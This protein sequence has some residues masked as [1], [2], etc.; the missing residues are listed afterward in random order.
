M[1]ADTPATVPALPAGV[2]LQDARLIDLLQRALPLTERPFADVGAELGLDEQQVIER[3]RRLLA[4]GVLTRFGP[5]FHIERAGGQFILA[6]LQAP[7]DRYDE[8]TA[9]VNALPEVAHNYRREHTLNM[10]F[11]VAAETSEGAWAAC[12]RIEAITGLPVHAFPKEREFFVGLYLPLLADSPRTS[13]DT[14]HATDA[15]VVASAPLSLTDF[16]RRL[17][18]V[19]QT[20]LPLQPRPYDAVAAA[21]GSSGPAVRA[22]LGELLAAGVVR[23]IAAVPNHY[24]LGYVANG[25][26]V[27]DVD[28]AEVDRLGQL[29]GSQPAVSHCYRRPRKPGVWRYNLFA[30]LHGHSRAE[31]L[32]QAEHVAALLGSACRAHDVLFSSAILKK[33][34]L[35]LRAA[36]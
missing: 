9:Q 6:A 24:R 5:L 11:V 12:E 30:M 17:I 21:I 2:D 33:T 3:L 7:E 18:A 15:P 19:T 10:W 20:G 26:S 32:A 1:P 27:W 29:L 22:R 36:A 13:L 8:V 16:D 25:M 34:G 4:D 31:V 28:D 23:R 14:L 35:R